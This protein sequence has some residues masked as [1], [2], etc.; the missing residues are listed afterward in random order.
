MAETHHRSVNQRV[1]DSMVGTPALVLNGRLDILTANELGFALYSPTYADPVRPPNNARFIFLDP[2][3]TE[4]FRDWDRRGCR[5]APTAR[6]RPAVQ[7]RG[8]CVRSEGH[9]AT[10]PAHGTNP[11][12]RDQHAGSWK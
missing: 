10:G 8:S 2:H 5:Y 6:S 4:F 1:L 9:A 12:F 3:A 11:G 7:P